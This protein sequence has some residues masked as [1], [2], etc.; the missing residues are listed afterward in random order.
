MA[1]LADRVDG[2]IGVDT[3]RDTLTAAAVTAVGGLLGQLVVTADAAGYQRLLG[4]ARS[5]VPGRRCFAVEGAGSY[6]AGLTRLLVERGEWVVEVD[7]PSRPARR[8]GKT[9]ALDAIRAAREA[10]VHQ[11]PAVPRRRGDR[12]AL[13]V[14]LATRH[15][16]LVARTC[17]INQ[18]K[19]L[20]VGAP[21][22]LRAELRGRS[23]NGQVTWCAALRDRPARSLEHR[24]TARALRATAQR[25][26]VLAAEA[27]ELQDEIGRLVAA[28]APWLLELPGI[29]PISAAQVLVSWSHAG[30]LRSEAAFAALAGASPIPASSGQVT[31]H[32]LNRGGDR[33]LNRTLHTVALVRLRDDPATRA[34]AARRRAEGKSPREIRRCVKRAIARQ[35]FKPLQQLDRFDTEVVRLC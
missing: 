18:L 25:I 13:R 14:L 35:L 10:L 20:I 6:G 8:G 16:A 22:E 31:R 24:M 15:G 11:R 21:E 3:H 2:V 27:A 28:V 12:E 32:R 29:G 23:T 26:R 4:F 9:D 17:A 30:R 19:A 7:R 34:Y 1:M 5:H 33:R